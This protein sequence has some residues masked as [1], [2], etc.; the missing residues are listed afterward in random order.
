M[1]ER[2]N[3]LEKL[4]RY[5]LK[6]LN[7]GGDSGGGGTTG[8]YIPL[9]GTEVGKPVTGIIETES[10]TGLSSTQSDLIIGIND[11]GTDLGDIGK[12]SQIY[13]GS[14]NNSRTTYINSIFNEL[15]LSIGTTVNE[16]GLGEI[17]IQGNISP[18][19]RG[20]TS[21]IDFTQ[22]ITSLDYT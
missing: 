3:K 8:D 12:S 11:I 6:M 22:N 4:V 21:L 17:F 9:P 16:D 1:I 14:S 5:L 20:I 13:F 2:L 18:L 19:S 15:N 7:G 10:I